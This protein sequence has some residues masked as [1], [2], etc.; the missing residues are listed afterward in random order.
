M[1]ISLKENITVGFSDFWS[2]KIRSIIT[3]MGIVLG[4]MSIIVVLALVKGINNQTMKWMMERGGL[5]KITVSRNWQ[6]DKPDYV[7]N[8]FTWKELELIHSLIPEAKYFNPQQRQW[9][10]HSYK[11]KD[12]RTSIHGVLPDFSKIEE[13]DVQEGRFISSF[14][15]EQ[16]NDVVVIGTTIKDELFGNKKAV[17]EIITVKDRRLKVIGIMAFRYMKN[18]GAIGNENSFSYLNRR[19]FTPLTTM[20]NK[21]SG[22]DKISSFTLKAQ[23]VES[24]PA[25]REKLNNIILN[26]RRGLPVFEV[27]SAKE[28][29][30]E[31]AQNQK[32]F[33]TI[34]YIISVI[35]LLVGAIVIANIMLATIQ[36]RTREIGIRLTVGARRRDIFVQFLVQ[37]ILVTTIGGIVGIII[38]LSLL[39][40]VSNFLGIE[41]IAGV[42]MIFVALIVS[43][44][45]GFISGII[46][47]IIA[48]KLDPVEA[49]RYE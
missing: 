17:G 34:F 46:P 23:D 20:I 47:A 4:T 38:G 29:A 36:E 2:R 13:W 22:N 33:Q 21:G 28:E 39:N 6:Y 42:G 3:V 41:L 25:L 12:Y 14:D 43:A 31:M 35:S 45:V 44:G 18:S 5:S 7:R 37:T 8:Y 16:S 24:A 10:R 26:L 49:L 40:L 9:I 11:D 15:I 1:A 32:M 48:S 19:S 30:E 27:E